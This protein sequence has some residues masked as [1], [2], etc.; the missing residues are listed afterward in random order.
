VNGYAYCGVSRR[1][2][3]CGAAALVKQTQILALWLPSLLGEGSRGEGRAWWHISCTH[4]M[5]PVGTYAHN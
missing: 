3:A 4:N 5:V 1:A 2:S